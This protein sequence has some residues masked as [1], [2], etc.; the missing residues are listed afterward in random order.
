MHQI[1]AKVRVEAISQ[2]QPGLQPDRVTIA[3]DC[4]RHGVQVPV[5]AQ[6]TLA[7]PQPGALEENPGPAGEGHR[8]LATRQPVIEVGRPP[9]QEQEVVAAA[10]PP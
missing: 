9:A 10:A 3:A 5:P 8:S 4:F 6:P 7:A 2:V 1:H